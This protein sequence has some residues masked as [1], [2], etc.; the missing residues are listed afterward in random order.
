MK[1]FL[2]DLCIAIVEHFLKFLNPDTS[3]LY[4]LL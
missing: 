4:K 2:L 1:I 3:A